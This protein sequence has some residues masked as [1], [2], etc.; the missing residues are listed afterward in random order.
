MGWAEVAQVGSEIL[1]KGIDQY[2]ANRAFS[3]NKWMAREQ[4]RFQERMASTQY[5]RAAKDLEAAGLNRVLALG[6][7]ASAPAGASATYQ[8]AKT[9][10]ADFMAIASAK[11]AIEGQK[12]QNRL[13]AAEADKAEAT[14]LP[15][16]LLNNFLQSNK[17]DIENFL[18][19]FISNSKDALTI[20]PAEMLQIDRYKKALEDAFS[21]AGSSAR[22]VY[23]DTVK[24]VKKFVSPNSPAQQRR[25]RMNRSANK[26]K[27]KELS[28]DRKSR[29][30]KR[31]R[32]RT[33]RNRARRR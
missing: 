19:N 2:N 12:Q 11:E 13:L 31:S 3:K 18:R 15:Y 30:I 10:K 28:D 7:P 25:M 33:E 22:D 24:S 21:A 14:K 1:D 9:P 6:S 26:I 5:Q 16:E 27:Y 4:M 29:A 23:E 32:S 8:Q 20:D 17:G